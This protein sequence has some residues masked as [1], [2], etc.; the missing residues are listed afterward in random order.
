MGISEMNIGLRNPQ[1]SKDQEVLVTEVS[2]KVLGHRTILMYSDYLGTVSSG[3]P[4]FC[5]SASGFALGLLRAGARIDDM[6][7]STIRVIWF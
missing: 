1:S 7:L 3:A 4:E 2:G 5:E 6:F